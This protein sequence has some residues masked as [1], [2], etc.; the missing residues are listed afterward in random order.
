MTLTHRLSLC[1]ICILALL[2]LARGAVDN[3]NLH[4]LDYIVYPQ[5]TEEEAAVLEW[6]HSAIISALDAS[7]AQFGPQTT[8]AA[9][10]EVECMPILA[11]PLNGVGNREEDEEG[12]LPIQEL[13]NADDVR[14]NMVVMTDNGGLSAVGM[15]KVAKLSGAAALLVVNIDEKRPDDIYRLE[16]MDGEDAEDIDIPV[17][18]I[19]LNSANVLTTA[20][21]TANMAKEDIVNN[22]MPDRVRL[23]AGGDRP[24]FEDVEPTDPTLY[25]IHNL[26]TDEEADSLLQSAK[27]KLSPITDDILQFS[28]DK[29]N[30]ENVQRT[31]VW[32]GMLQSPARKAVEERI[33]QVTGFPAAHHSD[34]VI[35]R[36]DA[37]VHW[38]AHYDTHPYL[39]PMATITVFLTDNGGSVVFPSAKEPVEI[40]PTKGMAIVHHNTDN[41][42]NMDLSSVHAM[43]AGTEGPAYVARKFIFTT[44]VSNAR[45]IALPILALPFGG[46]LPGFVSAFHDFMVEKFGMEDGPV[47]FDKACVFIP[48]LIFLSIAQLVADRVQGKGD[49]KKDTKK[50]GEGKKKKKGKKE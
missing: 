13:D 1:C 22:G 36:L 38:K 40:T 27:S 39:I 12:N 17:V 33:E 46:K 32:Q 2:S 35:D 9:L 28:N 44:P 3:K 18:M 8:E 5:R 26:M 20:T 30:F 7:V 41:K 31:V 14:G 16:V 50:K 11:S 37:G 25:L 29:E 23:Y 47:Y 45:R 19:S 6:G 21:V 10:L 43:M 49:K 42:H 48:F 34:F 15:A 24:F 4:D